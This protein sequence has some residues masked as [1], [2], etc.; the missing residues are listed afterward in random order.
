MKSVFLISLAIF[1]PLCIQPAYAQ[2]IDNCVDETARLDATT[3]DNGI[4]LPSGGS[5]SLAGDCEAALQQNTQSTAL[6]LNLVKAL[7]WDG[8]ESSAAVHI[9][10]LLGSDREDEALELATALCA[11]TRGSPP[12]VAQTCEWGADY[13]FDDPFL[14]HKAAENSLAN[15]KPDLGLRVMAQAA[16]SGSAEAVTYL[17]QL[18]D[19]FTLSGGNTNA[20]TSHPPALSALD[21]A[22]VSAIACEAAFYST[23]EGDA[24]WADRGFKYAE[25]MT[26]FDD[27]ESTADALLALSE[28]NDPA[29]AG[30]AIDVLDSLCIASAGDP[31]DPD[32][33]SDGVPDV[34]L[35][36]DRA[37][38]V[39]EAAA[40]VW[41]DNGRLHY[42]LARIYSFLGPAEQTYADDALAEALRLNYPLA[43]AMASPSSVPFDVKAFNAPDYIQAFHD[44]NMALLNR[45]PLYALNYAMAMNAVFSQD[46]VLFLGDNAREILLE[47]DPSLNHKA[48]K[49]LTDPALFGDAINKGL[50]SFL[51]PLTKIAEVRQQGGTIAEEVRGLHGA[52]LDSPVAQINVLKQK[53]KQDGQRL[54]I[55][56]DT[57]PA[58]F[59]KIYTGIKTFI[60][61]P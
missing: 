1:L 30:G 20:S 15:N 50:Q 33:G 8:R 19:G 7:I 57:N 23:A 53:A 37:Q 11:Y 2:A 61:Q 47:V 56:Y 49:K 16:Q 45:E 58:D 46:N 27:Y 13:G 17:N 14:A 40:Y 43:T 39:C 28:S 55:L 44:Q 51:G 38:P 35:F 31:N 5:S 12:V 41:P 42:N 32:F 59:R 60:E 4:T 29:T 3:S 24:M 10:L 26:Y 21:P 18:C 34:M 36:P 9:E 52:L 6:R 48:A 22:Y 54:A 25:A